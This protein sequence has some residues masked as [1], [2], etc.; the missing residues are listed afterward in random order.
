MFLLPSINM[1]LRPKIL[2]DESR[3]ARRLEH[4]HDGR[5]GAGYETETIGGDCTSWC[6]AHLWIV[7]AQGPGH[8][9]GG[10]SALT[11]TQKFQKID[12]HARLDGDHRRQAARR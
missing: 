1:R 11:L 12:R 7:P 6:T 5:L 3:H 2:E 9:A 10:Q 4:V 8:V